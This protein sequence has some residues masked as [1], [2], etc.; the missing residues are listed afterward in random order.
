VKTIRAVLTYIQRNAKKYKSSR[1]LQFIM[2]ILQ[3]F[4][5]CLEHILKFMNKNAYIITAI[6]GTSF[7][8]STRK[9]FFLLL[10]NILRVAAVNLVS[11]FV[12]YIG[13]LFIPLATTFALY[14]VLAYWINSTEMSGIIGPLVFT[15]VLSYFVSSVFI[16]IYGMGI[17]TILMCFIADEE[18]FPPGDRFA[19]GFLVSTIDKTREKYN[20]LYGAVP[21]VSSFPCIFVSL[22]LIVLLLQYFRTIWMILRTIQSQVLL[23]LEAK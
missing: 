13:R 7:C 10:R 20:K 14:L 9:A 1:I 4:M 17:E 3:C 16:E 19:E 18:M 21:L 6:Y 8:T 5:C 23:P 12:L 15:F 2:C 22:H 11:T